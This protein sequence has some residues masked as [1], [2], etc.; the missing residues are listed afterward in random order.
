MRS[1]LAISLLLAG[2]LHAQPG[3]AA[4]TVI[5]QTG[6]PLAE[7]HI[8]LISGDFD[9]DVGV[10]I[11]YGTI[12][13]SSGQFSMDGLKA[14]L[15]RV[16]VERAGLVQQA[17]GP[18]SMLAVKPGQHLTDYKIVMAARA[19][20]VGRV[21]DEYGDPVQGISVQIEPVPPAQ[22][23]GFMFGRSFGPT[24]DRGEFRILTQPGKY[25]LK[26]SE[27][28]RYHGPS[29]IRTDGTNGAPFTPTYYP[30]AVNAGS[31]AVI[32]VTPGQDLAGVDI[33]LLRAS[34]ATA[35]T[36]TISGVVMGAPDNGVANVMLHYGEAPG[37]FLNGRGTSA[38]SDGKFRFT[39]MEPGYYIAAATYSSGKTSL[40]SIPVEFHLD[41]AN[42]SS[43]QLTLAP[44][45]EL[46]G[47]L[48]L[49]GD[50]PAGQSEQRAVRLEWAG[51]GSNF[52]QESPPTAQVGPDGS[53]HVSGIV[54]GK[55]KP[56]VEPMPENG[57]LKEIAVD[58]KAVPDRV[59][60][61]T[62]GVGGSRLKIT[63]SRNGG[64]ISGR[65]LGR[66]GEPAIGLMMV[67][68]STDARYLDEDNAAR[69]SDSKFSFKAIRP[70]KY[71][72]IALDIAEFMQVVSGSENEEL[73]QQLFDAAEE[74]E[75]KE[76]DHIYKDVP[77]LTK[78][79][80]KK[81]PR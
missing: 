5:D 22:S 52:G 29:E 65:V 47:K 57:Y 74:I 61:F 11:V 78:L 68:F 6:K 12:S 34:A 30:S 54:P 50:A 9:S 38:G 28:Q 8:R 56:V 10:T 23:Q 53:F 63:V 27:M 7:V 26:A 31:A 81:E 66:D 19:L 45:E 20:I 49:S 69:V 42:E 16:M 4:G 55:F 67:L 14:G 80:E 58:G 62:H 73:M 44:S 33:R 71:R 17:P 48:E 24:D 70:G 3:S 51:W 35:R 60:D 59:L 39:G 79:P 46:T 77:A 1:L 37:Q 64:Q 75:I 15:Y 18:L 32:Q 76:G 2:C 25:Y 36:F 43:L 40:Q 41:A 21:L 13:D 72:I